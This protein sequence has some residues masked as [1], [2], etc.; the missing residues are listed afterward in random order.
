[1]AWVAGYHNSIGECHD[2][3]RTT[4]AEARDVMVDELDQRIMAIEIKPSEG[5]NEEELDG[6][7]AARAHFASLEPDD[8]GA[9]DA[10]CLTFVLVPDSV[11]S[12]RDDIEVLAEVASRAALP[13]TR[14]SLRPGQMVA[15][16]GAIEVMERL[17]IIPLALLSR[18]V[19][20]DWGDIDP[21]DK[22]L[23]EAALE[24]GA[25]IFSV[26]GRGE[27]SSMGDHRSRPERN[28]DPPAR[29]LLGGSAMTDMLNQDSRPADERPG[30]HP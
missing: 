20:G 14:A 1:M 12:A 21:E 8:E 10:S 3:I 2:A 18:H 22:G 6:L 15:T 11:L 29:G 7:R 5:G 24:T 9:A 16:P 19:S 23:N 13:M 28:D 27:R 4:W 17:G 30:P 26:Y 25:R